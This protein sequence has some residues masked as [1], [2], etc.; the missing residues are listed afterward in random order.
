MQEVM[1]ETEGIWLGSGPD[2]GSM[3]QFNIHFR[4]KTDF[5]QRGQVTAWTGLIRVDGTTYT[6][7]GAPSGPAHVT[8]TA[9]SYTST[10]SIFTLTAG[11]VSMN[12]TF[13]SPIT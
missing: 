8:Q 1:E 13:L 4:P 5:C 11:A 6:W 9:F 12:V 3:S 7:M 10:R 2:F